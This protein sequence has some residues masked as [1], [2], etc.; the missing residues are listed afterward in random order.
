MFQWVNEIQSSGNFHNLY[1]TIYLL[2]NNW[3]GWRKCLTYHQYNKLYQ[4]RRWELYKL[5]QRDQMIYK[6]IVTSLCL[7]LVKLTAT[8]PEIWD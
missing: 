8:S 6:K 2:W 1:V 7:N 4:E 5:V 3:K